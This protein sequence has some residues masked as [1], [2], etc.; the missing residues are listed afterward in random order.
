MRHDAGRDDRARPFA[1]PIPLGS[2][3]F[4]NSLITMEAMVDG[5][6]LS[7]QLF[8]VPASAY[9]EALGVHLPRLAATTSAIARTISLLP[10]L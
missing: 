9:L 1:V 4:G 2:R 6:Q 8:R 3:M 5:V 10:S 7:T